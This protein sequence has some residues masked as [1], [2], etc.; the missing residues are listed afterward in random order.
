M[1]RN[2]LGDII[3]DD[4][5]PIDG[6]GCECCCAYTGPSGSAIAHIRSTDAGWIESSAMSFQ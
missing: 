2:I 4:I 1:I 5:V 6:C 3:P